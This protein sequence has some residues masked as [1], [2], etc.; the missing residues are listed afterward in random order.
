MKQEKDSPLLFLLNYWA[1]YCTLDTSHH[2]WLHTF[3]RVIELKRGM[4]LFEPDDDGLHRDYLYFV[5]DGLL[6]TLWWNL[7]G[8]R[9]IDRLLLPDD[10]VLTTRNLYTDKPVYYFVA[11]LRRSTV[12]RI[13]A[14]TLRTYKESCRE[15]DTLVDVMEQK[16]LKQYRAK[17]RLMLIKDEQERYAE[18]VRDD[19]MKPIRLLASQQEQAD[20]LNISRVTITRVNRN[21]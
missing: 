1:R 12:I 8:Y 3:G 14:D 7:D 2:E 15:A 13:P 5:C 20:Y 9:R 19:Y 6:A 17:N 18:F 16:K 11:A 10:N 21:I 4:R